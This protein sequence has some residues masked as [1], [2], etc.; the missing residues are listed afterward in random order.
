[1]SKNVFFHKI[2]NNTVVVKSEPTQLTKKVVNGV[3][4][5]SR[6]QGTLTSGLWCPCDASGNSIDPSTLNLKSNQ[7]IEGI[8]MS[9]SPVMDQ[10]DNSIE[11]GMY[12]AG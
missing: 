1:M 5:Y 10:D 12:W 4:I 2:V 3:T 8:S 7:E 11:T 9:D 6:T